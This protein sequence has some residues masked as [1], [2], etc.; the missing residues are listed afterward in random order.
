VPL[1]AN[2]SKLLGSCLRKNDEQRAHPTMWRSA[3]CSDQ[4]VRRSGGQTFAGGECGE[5]VAGQAQLRI[6]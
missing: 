1:L 6:G 4:S 2:N 3:S 5:V